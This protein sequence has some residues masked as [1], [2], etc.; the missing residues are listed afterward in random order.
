M[1][2]NESVVFSKRRLQFE[3]ILGSRTTI[4]PLSSGHLNLR[5]SIFSEENERVFSKQFCVKSTEHIQ[6]KKVH[7]GGVFD[8]FLCCPS[9]H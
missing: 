4:I 6:K 9:S 7:T 2:V 8:V 3:I 5:G 1:C